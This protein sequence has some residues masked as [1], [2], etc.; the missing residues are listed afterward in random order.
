[1]KHAPGIQRTAYPVKQSAEDIHIIG[2]T[3]PAINKKTPGTA[4]GSKTWTKNN[5]S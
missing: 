3:E 2:V 4:T 5:F 1:M